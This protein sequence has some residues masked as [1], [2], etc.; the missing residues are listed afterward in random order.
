M[1]VYLAMYVLLYLPIHCMYGLTAH[2]F[3]VCVRF[4][5]PL[6]PIGSKDLNSFVIKPDLICLIYRYLP[7]TPLAKCY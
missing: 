2:T 6:R 4:D 5:L 7:C 3:A 1:L